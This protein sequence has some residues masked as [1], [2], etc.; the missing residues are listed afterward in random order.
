MSFFSN[1]LL[2]L[3]FPVK[4]VV[5]VKR[6]EMVSVLHLEKCPPLFQIFIKPSLCIF[7]RSLNVSSFFEYSRY[8]IIC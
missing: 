4:R 7:S 5:A 2:W 1:S 3:E 8:L 6:K